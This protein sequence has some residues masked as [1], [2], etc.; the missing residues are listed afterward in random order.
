MAFIPAPNLV[1]AEVFA[2]KD[3]Q[4]IENR[5]TID[6][7]TTP[8]DAIVD[9][10]A[11]IVDVWA[12][13]HYF[14]HL[15]NTV[16]LRGVQATDVSVANGSQHLITPEGSV[17]GT[18]DAPAMPNEVTL[19][20]QLKTGSRGRSARGR[21]YILGLA[22]SDVTGENTF[23][24]VRATDLVADFTALKAAID[25]AGWSWVV[26]SYVANRVPRPGGPVY[27]PI[28]SVAFQDLIVDS[29]RSRKPGV[30][31]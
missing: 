5:F 22:R 1:T 8:T 6:V 30:G 11:N 13:A 27:F 4:Q 25:G 21:C 18:L 26:A 15:P 28:L 3:G 2:L 12:Q 20:L 16:S 10:V 14:H 23:W 17:V 19:C 24:S 7:L 31:T 29:M 9:D